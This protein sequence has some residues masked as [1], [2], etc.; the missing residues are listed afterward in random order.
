MTELPKLP[1]ND[2]ADSVEDDESL[3]QRAASNPD[4]FAAL[5]RRHLDRVY[6]Y[7]LARLAD[8]FLAQDVTAQTFLAALE[9]IGSY[10]HD[11]SVSAWLLGIARKK[12]VDAL[13]RQRGTLPLESATGLASPQPSPERVVAARVELQQVVKALRAITPERGEALALRV[14]GGLSVAETA[15]VLGKSE[16][17]IKMLVLRATQDLRTR[18]APGE[19]EDA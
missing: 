11:G 13:R 4:A 16:A 3:A 19:G 12:A 18:L 7:L 8:H 2:P 10:R 6:R 9:G 5:Y 1:A 17:A 15:R 14:F